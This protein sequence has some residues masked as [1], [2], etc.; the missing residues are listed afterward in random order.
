[1]DISNLR[2]DYDHVGLTRNDLNPDPI[3]QFEQWFAEARQTDMTDPTAMSLATAD[4][5]GEVGIRTVLLKYFDQNG[6][7]FFTN[8]SSLKARH[9]TQNPNVALL[10]PWLHLD[11]QVKIVGTAS[12]IS[13]AESLKYFLSRPRGSQLGAWVSA[14]SSVISS[15]QMLMAKLDEIRQRFADGEVSLPEFWGG[16]RVAARKIEFWQGRPDRLHDRFQYSREEGGS[17]R[18]DRLAP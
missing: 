8:Y 4:A 17:W 10:F 1:V 7:V 15:R 14:Q 13:T 2:R 11:R 16:Y 18:I 3:Q 12:R 5:D 6:F 9:I